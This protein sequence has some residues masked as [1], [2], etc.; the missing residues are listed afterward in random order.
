MNAIVRR[1]SDIESEKGQTRADKNQ[2]RGQPFKELPAAIRFRS[3]I[4]IEGFDLQRSKNLVEK[5]LN[6]TVVASN[7]KSSM[8]KMRGAKI[9]NLECIV[10][11]AF[12][13]VFIIAFF[14]GG[15]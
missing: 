2:I 4:V 9:D 5:R 6:Q 14:V 13:L 1:K 15:D 7:G 10:P 8:G 3:K 11:R 12:V